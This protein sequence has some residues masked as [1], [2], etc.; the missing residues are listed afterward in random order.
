MVQ[1]LPHWRSH[2]SGNDLIDFA[3]AYTLCAFKTVLRVFGA[4]SLNLV[5]TSQ[6]APSTI[7][8]ANH[9][10]DQVG[11]VVLLS[12]MGLNTASFGSTDKAR[13]RELRRRGMRS[14]L[15]MRA[16]GAFDP[17]NLYM[18]GMLLAIVIAGLHDGST[19]NKYT[20]GISHDMLGEFQL[21]AAGQ[22]KRGHSLTLFLGE[23]DLVFPVAEIRKSL[24]SVDL[25][26]VHIEVIPN[27]THTSLALK[28]GKT[29][30][31]RVI[32]A[33]RQKA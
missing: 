16:P 6:A 26:G 22:A 25:G 13:F 19:V 3:T 31:P 14:L 30:L 27:L 8:L 1:G 7:W 2:P 10:P 11:N 5:G 24:Q 15:Q 18:G 12:P 9:I 32:T 17:R 28:A 20:V 21:L 29:Y 4:K 33:V 23:K